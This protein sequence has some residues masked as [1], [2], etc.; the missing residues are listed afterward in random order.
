MMA[1]PDESRPG[2]HL[3]GPVFAA[4]SARTCGHSDGVMF[5]MVWHAPVSG[6]LVAS[7]PGTSQMT[8]LLLPAQAAMQARNRC[9]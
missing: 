1:S 9:F 2:R 8:P 6:A 3:G 7:H 5:V 4:P